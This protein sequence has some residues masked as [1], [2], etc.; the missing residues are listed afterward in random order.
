MAANKTFDKSR[1]NVGK[2]ALIF[3]RAASSRDEPM[4]SVE[5]DTLFLLLVACQ[6]RGILP[7]PVPLASSDGVSFFLS[8]Q[9]PV[10]M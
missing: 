6:Q 1:R 7:S 2:Q 3:G 9:L 5:E 10:F 4:T 8:R